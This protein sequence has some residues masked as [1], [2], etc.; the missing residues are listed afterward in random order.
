MRKGAVGSR[1]FPKEP[2]KAQ[3]GLFARFR[4]SASRLAEQSD[5]CL[6][7]QGM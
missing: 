3:N 4:V 5:V 7:D 1:D 6:K 2:G